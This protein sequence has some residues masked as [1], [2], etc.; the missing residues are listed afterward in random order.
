MLRFIRRTGLAVGAPLLF[1]ACNEGPPPAAPPVLPLDA[2]PAPVRSAG[3]QHISL[4][5]RKDKPNSSGVVDGLSIAVEEVVEKYM[6]TGGTSMRVKL[7]LSEGS[8]RET[9]SIAGGQTLS[10]HGYSIEY[11][12]AGWRDT[13]ELEI[14]RTEGP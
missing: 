14:S 7:T 12:T 5:A 11:S 10:W 9:V 13:V 8:A 4:G 1:V 3:K 2:G 6:N